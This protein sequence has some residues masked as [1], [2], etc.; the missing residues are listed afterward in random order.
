MGQG[1]FVDGPVIQNEPVG[2]TGKEGSHSRA[3]GLG[4]A[5]GN[6]EVGTGQWA[7]SSEQ[8]LHVICLKRGP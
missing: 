3:W 1:M 8:G 4:R 6:A 2:G 7:V 5:H